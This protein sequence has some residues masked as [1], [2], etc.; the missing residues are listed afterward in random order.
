MV[1][2]GIVRRGLTDQR[3]LDAM[4]EVPREAFVPETLS[5]HAYDDS[6]L[7][8]AEGQTISQPYIVAAM[9]AAAE[10]TSRSRVLEVGTGSGYGAAVLSCIAREVW[11]IERHES[12]AVGARERLAGLGYDN[13]HVLHGDGASGLAVEAPFDAIVVTAAA[14]EVPEALTD[15]L[16][17]GGRLVIP[18]GPRALQ[19]L[20]R[21]RRVGQQRVEDD[22][23]PV[24]FVDLISDA[25]R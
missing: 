12:L 23:G 5:D 1:K 6:P 3:V 19:R 17:D 11:T 24:R 9:A 15:Q 18:V 7:P 16:V 8:I 25:R 10:L 14:R 20:R 21:I 22:L 13:V 2:Q 4:R